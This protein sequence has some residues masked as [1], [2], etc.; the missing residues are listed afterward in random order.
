MIIKEVKEAVKHS[1]F[2]PSF[3]YTMTL[4][5]DNSDVSEHWD[6]VGLKHADL[7]VPLM[8]RHVP[9]QRHKSTTALR[10]QVCLSLGSDT[11]ECSPLPQR[12]LTCSVWG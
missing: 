7:L 4:F 5:T 8:H 6:G 12:Q 10:G 2:V 9:V 3:Y 11:A 1:Y